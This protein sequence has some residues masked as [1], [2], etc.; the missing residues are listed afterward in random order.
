MSR[1]SRADWSASVPWGG[2]I[3]K[4]SSFGVA[5]IGGLTGTGYSNGQYPAYDKVT[6][7]FRPASIIAPPTP[8]PIEPWVPNEM[9]YNWDDT[10]LHAFQSAQQ[11]F[12]FIGAFPAQPV[13]VGA[14]FA[15][16]YLTIS[17]YVPFA[18]TIRVTVMNTQISDVTVGSGTIRLILFP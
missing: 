10:T 11:D 14:S 18:N 8:T 6:G 7:R 4:P 5:D 2:V 9:W 17:A 12:D 3:D 16:D 15:I 13:A 1:V